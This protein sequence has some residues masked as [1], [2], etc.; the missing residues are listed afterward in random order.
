MIKPSLVTALEAPYHKYSGSVDAT[1]VV[2]SGLRWPTEYWAGLAVGW[3]EEGVSWNLDILKELKRISSDTVISQALRHRAFAL[4]R[5]MT[6]LLPIEELDVVR[7]VTLHQDFREFWGD[8]SVKRQPRVGDVG[9]VVRDYPVASGKA[10]FEVEAM[11]TD[12]I[13]LWVAAFDADELKLEE[14]HFDADV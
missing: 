4:V 5:Q 2:L 8:D 7:V 12:G 11:N 3:L 9:V 14:K 13:T 10:L 1:D 6:Q